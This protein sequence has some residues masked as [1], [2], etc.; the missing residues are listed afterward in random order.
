[1]TT[2]AITLIALS[3]LTFVVVLAPS[4]NLPLITDIGLAT[5]GLSALVSGMKALDGALP[6]PSAVI[7]AGL[8][9]FVAGA[10][11]VVAGARKR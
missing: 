11:L 7:L 5:V 2:Y 8:G 1:M 10:G 6:Q 9:G 4:I 3:M